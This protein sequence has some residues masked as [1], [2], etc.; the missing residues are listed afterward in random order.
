MMKVTSVV[1]ISVVLFGCTAGTLERADTFSAAQTNQRQESKLIEIA[2]IEKAKVQVNN[3]RAQK[4]AEL[5]GA[6]LGGL[7]GANR[8]T[9]SGGRSLLGAAIGG[10]AAGIAVDS[11][12]IVDGVS[13]TYVENG[14]L[15]TSAQVG[16]PCEFA[17]GP[18]LVITTSENE[19]RVQPNS[20]EPCVEGREDVA[21]TTSKVAGLANLQLKMGTKDRLAD[22]ERERELLQRESEV[23]NAKTGLQRSTTSLRA[24]EQRTSNAARSADQEVEA[25]DA[26]ID[27]T[28]AINEGIRAVSK[29]VGKGAEKGIVGTTTIVE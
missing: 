2:M 3:E 25:R 22:L 24:E 27:R 26:Q 13:L 7:V 20:R 28:R 17:L 16:K 4:S 6:L 8:D 29:G 1:A 15:L 23:M 18:A 19:T 10:T 11:Q 14:L 12:K 21:G 9:G 5:G